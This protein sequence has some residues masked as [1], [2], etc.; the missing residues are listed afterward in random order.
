MLGDVWDLPGQCPELPDLVLELAC[1]EQKVGVETHR[2]PFL[3]E[4]FCDSVTNRWAYLILYFYLVGQVRQS[5]Q[6]TQAATSHEV[7]NGEEIE[8]PAQLPPH[9]EFQSITQPC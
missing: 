5:Y 2:G 8:K 4:S 1:W 6:M 3:Y 7:S 9:S